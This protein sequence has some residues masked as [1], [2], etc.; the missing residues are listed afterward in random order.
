MRHGAAPPRPSPS[1]PRGSPSAPSRGP[2]SAPSRGPPSA[3]FRG[4]P[5][6][7]RR[8]A[9]ITS[10]IDL[11]AADLSRA[12]PDQRYG[13][14]LSDCGERLAGKVG[15]SAPGRDRKGPGRGRMARGAGDPGGGSLT[16]VPGRGTTQAVTCSPQRGWVRPASAASPTDGLHSAPEGPRVARALR[17]GHAPLHAPRFAV[18]S[19]R[20]RSSSPPDDAISFTLPIPPAPRAVRSA[21]QHRRRFA[22]LVL[23]PVHQPQP[24]RLGGL[25][26]PAGQAQL[27]GR[28]PAYQRGQHP[29]T[30]SQVAAGRADPAEP[31][32]RP[33]DAQVSGRGELGATATAGPSTTAMTGRAG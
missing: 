21:S 7:P 28:A 16:T 1:A 29:G 22:R 3:P 24:Q 23:D 20:N 33:G 11:E 2:P 18:R 14:N 8:T 9:H 15:E 12:T 19:A 30:D 6:A 4:S 31:G 5:S 10:H 32:A 13:G 26:P 17:V 25:D 27:Q